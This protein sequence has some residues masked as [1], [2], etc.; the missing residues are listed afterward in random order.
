[1]HTILQDTEWI[2]RRVRNGI[3]MLQALHHCHSPV[4]I[5]ETRLPDGDWRDLFTHLGSL[6]NPPNL[7]LL[8]EHD[9][10][11]AAEFLNLG[12]FDVLEKPLDRSECLHVCAAAHRNWT[13]ARNATTLTWRIDAPEN[14]PTGS[15][16]CDSQ[17]GQ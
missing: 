14:R 3:E 17:V 4:V 11:L 12:G 7:I 16:T 13:A 15:S 5:C 10:A 9:I 1:M 2:V 8:S 6:D